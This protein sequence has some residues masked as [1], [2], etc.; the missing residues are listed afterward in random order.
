MDIKSN[1]LKLSKESLY[2]T[3]FAYRNFNYEPS[4]NENIESNLVFVGLVG[5]ENPCKENVQE[6]MDYCRSLAIKPII[7]TEDNKITA[8]SIG[9]NLGI[10]NKNDMV[11]SGVEIDNMD[12][13]EL[14]KFIEKV[15]MYSKISSKIKS[16][17][18]E[19]FKKLRSEEH[20]SELQS[21]QYLVC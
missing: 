3:G 16:K 7:I 15:S 12:D 9:N 2:V 10:L 14:E 4:V 1:D 17:V 8:Q 20:T 13:A 11:L 6:Y 21:R 18:C 19:Q 5:F